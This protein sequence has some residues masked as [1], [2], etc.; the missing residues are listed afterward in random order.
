MERAVAVI[1]CR[2]MHGLSWC[3]DRL[4]SCLS[5]AHTHMHAVR[6]RESEQPCVRSYTRAACA[7]PVSSPKWVAW[8]EMPTT[9]RTFAGSVTG[10][11]GDMVPSSFTSGRIDLRRATL[12]LGP[13]MR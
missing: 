2:L 5:A 3:T 11:R 6:V 4:M 8:R 12:E 7:E 9:L 13:I 10:V 1:V